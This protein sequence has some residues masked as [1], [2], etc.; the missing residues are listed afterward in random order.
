MFALVIVPPASEEIR[1]N[2]ILSL[3]P[4]SQWQAL[5]ILSI[6]L[7]ADGGIQTGTDLHSH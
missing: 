4:I 3:V 5:I 2:R 1:M 7:I 6:K